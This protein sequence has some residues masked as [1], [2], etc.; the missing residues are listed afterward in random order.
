MKP[1]KQL[2]EKYL[3]VKLDVETLAQWKAFRKGRNFQNTLVKQA[4]IE[5]IERELKK[6]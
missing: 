3:Q 5:F 6:S 1:I 4:L 2:K